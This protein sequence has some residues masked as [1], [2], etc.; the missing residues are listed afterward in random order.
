MP[1]AADD[2]AAAVAELGPIRFDH[3]LELALYGEHGFYATDGVAGRRGD[4]LTSPEV[5]PLF[6]AVLARFVAAERDRLGH[7]ADF[8]VVE[9]GAGPGT[10][11][12][13]LLARPELAGITYVAVEVSA[14][15]RTRHPDGVVSAAAM[16]SE[17]VDGVVIANELLDNLPFRLLVFDGGWREAHVDVTR[18]GLVEVLRAI[19]D[20][21]PAWLPATAPHGARVPWHRAAAEWVV[22]AQH[23][24]RSGSVLAFDYVTPRTAQLALEPWRQWLRTYR[25]HERGGHYLADPGGQD[26]T[27]QVALDQLPAPDAVR[28]QSQFLQRWGIDELVEEGRRAW[29]AGAAAPTVAALTM[30]SRVREAEALLDPTGLGGF[31][32]LE[33]RAAPRPVDEVGG[34]PER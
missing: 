29:E 1:S 16:P 18:D 14:A 31:F 3:Y 15:Q 30:R 32:A 13:S 25:G 24:T 10:L 6:G 5:G 21:P 4:F 33:W 11:A 9:V 27:T 20:A 7:P 34:E 23:L 22:A 17:P 2:V 28:T 12:R 19:D 8:T 26:I